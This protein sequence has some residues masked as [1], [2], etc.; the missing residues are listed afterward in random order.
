MSS[1]RRRI[2]EIRWRWPGRQ[3]RIAG[4]RH[5]DR[6]RGQPLL[7]IGGLQR[8]R[9][10]LDQALQRLAHLV[11]PLP[12]GP[13]LLGRQLADRAQH[14]G[15]PATCAPGS[16]PAAP[17]ARPRPSA[18][19][20]AASASLR[21]WSR[22]GRA[23][24]S[25]MARHPIAEL[26]QGH[27]G[28]H[29]HVQRLGAALA[30]RYAHRLGG[31]AQ[32]LLGQPLALRAQAE[33]ERA[34]QP[35]RSLAASA[36]GR[37]RARPGPPASPGRLAGS[38]RAGRP[39]EH[40]PHAGPH[41]LGRERVRAARA[42]EHRAVA[43]RVGRAQ[44]P[45]PRC[46]GRPRRAGRPSRR[47]EGSDQRCAVHADHPRARSER[48]HRR[49][50]GAAPRPPPTAAAPPAATPPRSAAATRSSP[51]AANRPS[52]SRQR[53]CWSLRIVFS[54][55][56]WGEVITVVRVGLRE[57]KRAPRWAPRE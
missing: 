26:V 13:A 34:G 56:L 2:W 29:G 39:R 11:G 37:L 57:R 48:A 32:D 53:R 31:P 14:L 6:V 55:S 40:R 54:C 1:I 43:E 22:S 24:A 45:R 49:P 9:A 36:S 28:G 51:S 33:H 27:R 23:G 3:R 4:Q 7:Q 17:P 50:A 8:A 19:A 20:T 12:G 38:P 10:L 16:A 52:L 5:V 15:E 41:R 18:A 46:R 30:Q 21:S 44:R 25:D 47:P 42:Q 35:A